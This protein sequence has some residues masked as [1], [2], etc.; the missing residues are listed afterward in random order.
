MTRIRNTVRQ[1]AAAALLAACAA[2]SCAASAFAAADAAMAPAS[3]ASPAGP[4]GDAPEGQG[5]AAGPDDG[6]RH[7]F[8]GPRPGAPGLAA[9]S[10]DGDPPPHPGFGLFRRL[11]GLDLSEAQQD[12]LFAITHAAAPQQRD[13]EKAERKAH[14]ALRALG[15][16]ARFDEARASA[17]ARDLGQA[18]ANGVL[19]R[20]RLESQVLG[21][22]TPEQREQLGRERPPGPPER[23]RQP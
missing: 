5:P 15:A 3:D 23:P 9:P 14:D 16:S 4:R 13:Q 18:I 8:G 21:L 17:A 12:K 11:R 10:L 2:A 20:V 22:L 1:T 6:N 19:L 7:R